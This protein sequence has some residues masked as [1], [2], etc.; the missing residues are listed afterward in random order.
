MYYCG[1]IELCLIPERVSLLHFPTT[2]RIKDVHAEANSRKVKIAFCF[3]I[4]IIY[5]MKV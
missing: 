1:R 2:L 3:N 4:E 5:N